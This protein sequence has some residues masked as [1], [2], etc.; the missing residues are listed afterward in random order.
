[1]KKKSIIIAVVIIVVA[2]II[3]AIAT[4]S[5]L[6]VKDLEQEGNLKTEIMDLTKVVETVTIDTEK[7]NEKINRVITS[8]DYAIVEKACKDYIQQSFDNVIQIT[9]LLNSDEIVK[10]LTAENYHE[11]GPDFVKTTLWVKQ[12]REKVEEAKNK[13]VEDMTEEHVMSYINGKTSDEYYI[14]LYRQLTLGDGD[15]TQNEAIAEVEE[16]LNSIINVLNVQ[17]KIINFLKE[18]KENWQI[19]DGTIAFTTEELTNE[20]NNMLLELQ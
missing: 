15:N 12:T 1:M 3:A 19:E 11:D 20:Y 5:F 17:E 8:G 18:N 7:Y 9:D 13:Y 4:I 16:S 6:V 14:D 10:I 2:L